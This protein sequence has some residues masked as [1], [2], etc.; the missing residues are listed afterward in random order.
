MQFPNLSS[1]VPRLSRIANCAVHNI[2]RVRPESCRH[3]TVS[4]QSLRYFTLDRIFRQ[5]VQTNFPVVPVR[6]LPITGFLTHRVL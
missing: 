6:L 2:D 3:T 5:A 4:F 1:L